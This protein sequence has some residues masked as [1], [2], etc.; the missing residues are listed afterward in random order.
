VKGIYVVG[1][2]LVNNGREMAKLKGVFFL[3][4][5]SLLA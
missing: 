3:S 4:R 5:Q 2:K 1:K